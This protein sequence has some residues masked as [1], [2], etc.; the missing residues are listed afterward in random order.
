MNND[1]EKILIC[2]R[3]IDRPLPAVES[4]KDSCAHCGESVWRALS[5]PPA[6]MVICFKCLLAIQAEVKVICVELPTPMQ[7][8]DILNRSKN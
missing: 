8:K 5:S 1:E 4:V 7:F 2:F 3:T 6:D